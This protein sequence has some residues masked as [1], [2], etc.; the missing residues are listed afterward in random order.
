VADDL[1]ETEPPLEDELRVLRELRAT[2][3]A[4]A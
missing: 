4:A 1:R 2:L 3:E